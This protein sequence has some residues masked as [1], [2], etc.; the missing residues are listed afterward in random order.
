LVPKKRFVFSGAQTKRFLRFSQSH[1]K[2]KTFLWK[3]A[4]LLPLKIWWKLG[5]N[6]VKTWLHFQNLVKTW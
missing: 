4:A 6:L 5:E 1:E 3:P 2:G